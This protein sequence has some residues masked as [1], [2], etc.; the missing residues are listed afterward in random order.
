[1]THDHGD[2]EN[3]QLIHYQA[4]Q[5]TIGAKNRRCW[6]A[7]GPMG[8]IHRRPC[9]DVEAAGCEERPNKKWILATWLNQLYDHDSLYNMFIHS[10]RL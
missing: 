4:P 7:M 6:R 2:P 1:M 9:G 3:S 8:P 5:R 10:S